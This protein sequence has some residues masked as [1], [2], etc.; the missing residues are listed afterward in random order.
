MKKVNNSKKVNDPLENT[1]FK[2]IEKVNS[3][4]TAEDKDK[5]IKILESS[6]DEYFKD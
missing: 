4:M 2:R 3:T 6:F 5:F 1:D